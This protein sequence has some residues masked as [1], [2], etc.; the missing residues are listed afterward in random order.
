MPP[1]KETHL[2]LL[3]LG[4]FPKGTFFIC[5]LSQKI[6]SS[7][8]LQFDVPATSRLQSGFIIFSLYN[9]FLFF[10]LLHS[11]LAPEQLVWCGMDSVLLYWDDMLLMVG[12]YGDLV[13]Y[14]YDEPIIIIPECDGSRILS[15]LNMEFLQQAPASTESIFKIGSIEPTSLLYDA[16]DH[17]D[18]RNAKDDENLRLIKTSLPEAVKVF[19]CYKT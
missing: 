14:L 12:P 7:F 1:I 19:R 8:C 11:T 5:L 18:R 10:L 4:S 15:N 3:L 16:L 9:D 2:I 6:V 17:F 13:R